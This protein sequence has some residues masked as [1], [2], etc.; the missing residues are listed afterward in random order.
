[1]WHRPDNG[2]NSRDAYTTEVRNRGT[3]RFLLTRKMV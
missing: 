3:Q 1:M 2:R